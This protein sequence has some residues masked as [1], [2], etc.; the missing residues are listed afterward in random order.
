MMWQVLST[1]GNAESS[2]I[3]LVA[4]LGVVGLVLYGCYHASLVMQA[5]KRVL[6]KKTVASGPYLFAFSWLLAIACWV[7]THDTFANAFGMAIGFGLCGAAFAPVSSKMP[8]APFK[9]VSRFLPRI[10]EP[11]ES[12]AKKDS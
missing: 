4:E 3:R 6:S 9:A 10:K 12:L 8:V 7:I 5:A 2:W 1:G 11:L